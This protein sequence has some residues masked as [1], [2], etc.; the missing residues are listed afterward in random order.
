M[1]SFPQLC[2]KCFEKCKSFAVIST[3]DHL[4]HLVCIPSKKKP[5]G[6][7]F[8]GFKIGQ[9]KES[10][11]NK[12]GHEKLQREKLNGMLKEILRKIREKNNS[13]L[14]GNEGAS[15]VLELMGQK[16]HVLRS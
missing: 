12:F 16:I 13:W 15:V 14:V 3:C 11:K 2:F 5:K 4:I 8:E 9:A 6:E 1:K 7:C 10:K